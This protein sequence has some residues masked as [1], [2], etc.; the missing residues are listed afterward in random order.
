MKQFIAFDD[1]AFEQIMQRLD[2]LEKK[3]VPAKVEVGIGWLNNEQ[4]CEALQISKRTAQNYRDQG[5][6]R[7]SSIGGK[8]YYQKEDVQ[9]L[10]KQNIQKK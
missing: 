7:Y 8:V 3:L 2:Q 5:L 6:V 1:E 10:L 4:F 9:N